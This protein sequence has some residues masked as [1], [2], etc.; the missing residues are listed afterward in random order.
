LLLFS[1]IRLRREATVGEKTPGCFGPDGTEQGHGSQGGSAALDADD[2]QNGPSFTG[3][4]R[5]SPNSSGQKG[6]QTA[7]PAVG[8]R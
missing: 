7:R 1:P 5:E 3:Q 8:C 6:W 2:C 4:N